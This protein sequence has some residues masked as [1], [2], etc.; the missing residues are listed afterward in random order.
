MVYTLCQ[1]KYI[2]YLD[3]CAVLMS[4]HQRFINVS[5]TFFLYNYPTVMLNYKENDRKIWCIVSK[6]PEKDS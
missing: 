2:A 6:E 1:E 3:I 4:R 5:L